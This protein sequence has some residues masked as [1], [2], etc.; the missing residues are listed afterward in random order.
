[1]RW[2]IKNSSRL[3]GKNIVTRNHNKL[4]PQAKEYSSPN[5]SNKEMRIINIQSDGFFG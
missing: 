2:Y 5:Y 3:L 4:T 1:M